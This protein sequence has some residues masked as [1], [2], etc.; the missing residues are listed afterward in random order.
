[1]S[2]LKC[3]ECGKMKYIYRSSTGYT[4]DYCH[5]DFKKDLVK[6]AS[7][8][9]LEEK[10]DTILTW[11]RK[12]TKKQIADNIADKDGRVNYYHNCQTGK[13]STQLF[14]VIRENGFRFLDRKGHYA[15]AICPMYDNENNLIVF[16]KCRI[17]TEKIEA[18]EIRH[19]EEI[20]R[21]YITPDKQMYHSPNYWSWNR[22]YTYSIH[23][24]FPNKYLKTEYSSANS[25]FDICKHIYLNEVDDK[26]FP[27]FTETV[28]NIIADKSGIVQLSGNKMAVIDS[29]FTFV[30]YMRTKR[31][32]TKKGGPKQAKI[33][34]LTKYPLPDIDLPSIV[35]EAEETICTKYFVKNT[36]TFAV[37]QKIDREVPTCV[38]RTFSKVPGE[39]SIREGY[40][41]YVEKKDVYTCKP[42][43][44]G[45]FL[46]TPLY[47]TPSNWEFSIEEFNPDLV[48]GTVL[49]Y[50]GEVVNKIDYTA[51]S[52][53]IWAFIKWPIIEQI[54]KAGYINIVNWV[55]INSR[56]YDPYKV[57]EY[58][59]G[60]LSDDKKFLK[61]LGM[62]SAQLQYLN[63][64]I[65]TIK[66]FRGGWNEA[67]ILS[68]VTLAKDVLAGSSYY[69]SYWRR[70][71]G[72]SYSIAD[73]D[74]ESFKKF[75]DFTISFISNL[76]M[77]SFNTE[78]LYVDVFDEDAKDTPYYYIYNNFGN[79]S[80]ALSSLREIYGNP[81]LY[82]VMPSVASLANKKI[83]KVHD[84]GGW[85]TYTTYDDAARIY[86]DYLTMVGEVR[87]LVRNNNEDSR[88]M[89]A[90][91]ERLNQS[92]DPRFKDIEQLSI[93]HDNL[94][95]VI[96]IMKNAVELANWNARRDSWKKWEF[97]D[98]ESGYMTIAPKS[99][100]DLSKEGHDLCHCVK[101][102]IPRVS[103]GQTNIMFIR[104]IA[105][106]ETCFFTVEVSNEGCI[107]Q[108]HGLRNVNVSGVKIAEPNLEKFISKWCKEKK[109][110]PNGY[111]KVR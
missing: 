28:K 5:H 22:D 73:V 44:K 71:E 36:E 84:Y 33:D 103:K 74:I 53:A 20:E 26:K 105:D 30:E 16:I 29:P 12:G 92:L 86:Y 18:G 24:L 67:M 108:V 98:E 102:Y 61:K 51:R 70:T 64:N 38:L 65:S 9:T 35:S 76:N 69:S 79:C 99:P 68:P 4:C 96:N 60:K 23:Y 39:D 43:S 85:R 34:E 89:E 14:E 75:V 95:C 55:L 49:E 6:I 1:M 47:S 58:L 100:T 110:K 17:N 72:N 10:I 97:K 77:E 88:A 32:E 106:P 56:Q 107:E 80:R 93:M 25:G 82:S 78:K 62:S 104:K 42:S 48:R 66:S 41:M 2:N 3:P 59:F 13:Q 11:N 101:G 83:E 50:F 54:A 111:N 27:D 90:E 91:L 57:L 109:L 46:Y 52:K 81:T 31:K 21:I 8:V 87:N 7:N 45:E 15:T 94:V 19:W 63:D 40:R 37:I